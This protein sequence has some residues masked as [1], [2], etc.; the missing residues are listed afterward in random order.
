M[1]S[2]LLIK[3]LITI[4]CIFF[5]TASYAVPVNLF[6]E[7]TVNTARNN[8]PYN[9]N[10]GDR[11]FANASFES[12]LISSTGLSE[13]GLGTTG[14]AFGG[15]LNFT[16]G[17]RSFAETDDIDYLNFLFPTLLF[18]DGIFT[19][20]EFFTVFGRNNNRL[21][22]AVDLEFSGI[23]QNNGRT[24]IAGEWDINSLSIT[25]TEVPEPSSFIL[26]GLGLIGLISV[27]RKLTD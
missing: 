26:M 14:N 11:V 25:P 5:S 4:S 2:K 12:S 16:I 15:S 22:G 21:F 6:I 18:D 3:F 7:G 8:N 1:S 9:V 27:K 13:V 24:Q 19:G 20:F 17:S 10:V 23:N